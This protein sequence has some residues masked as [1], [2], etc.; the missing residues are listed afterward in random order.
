MLL[1]LRSTYKSG[2]LVLDAKPTKTE[3]EY[4]VRK[5]IPAGRCMHIGAGSKPMTVATAKL[6]CSGANRIPVWIMH[7]SGEFSTGSYLDYAESAGDNLPDWADGSN[8]KRVWMFVGLAGHELATTEF[9]GDFS[10]YDVGQQLKSVQMDSTNK[11]GASDQDFARNT[12][13]KVTNVDVRHGAETIIGRVSPG[14]T[15]DDPYRDDNL[16]PY[17]NELLPF[18]TDYVPPLEATPTGISAVATAD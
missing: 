5:E 6:G 10:T 16:D 12:A 9:I 15:D 4:F 2:H 13:G 3:E 11:G 14:P 7:A 1:P 17:R 18:Y 8:D